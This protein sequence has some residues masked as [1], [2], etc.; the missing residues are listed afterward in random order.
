MLKIPEKYK[1]SFK[2]K[3]LILLELKIV[4]PYFYNVATNH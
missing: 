4:Q 3:N 1:I 2:N